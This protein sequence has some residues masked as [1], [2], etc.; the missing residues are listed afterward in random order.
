MNELSRALGRTLGR[1]S[2]FR[3]PA[4]AVRA[5]FG[6]GAAPLLTGQRVVPRRAGELG[7][8][9]RWR[10][11]TPA[12]NDILGTST[13]LRGFG[14][15][16]VRG[17]QRGRRTRKIAP[18]GTASCTVTEPPSRATASEQNVSPRPWL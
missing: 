17:R 14:R 9:F 15:N 6:E 2:F 1:P 13:R 18:V 16:D 12:L 4:F 8:A 5:A 11:L 3:V 7:Y 10:E